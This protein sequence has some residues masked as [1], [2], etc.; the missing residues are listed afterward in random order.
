MLTDLSKPLVG[1][2]MGSDSDLPIMKDASSF[3]DDIGIVTELKILSAHRTPQRM[4]KYAKAARKKGIRVIIA[5][6]GGSAHLPGMIDFSN[7]LTSYRSSHNV[8]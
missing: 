1:I 7:Y 8:K 6:A 3:L 4:V 5:G 2:V